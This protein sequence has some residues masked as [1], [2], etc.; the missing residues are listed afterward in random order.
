MLRNIKT[1]STNRLNAAVRNLQVFHLQKIP[2]RPVSS[3]TEMIPRSLD[4]SDLTDCVAG[5]AGLINI[6]AHSYVSLVI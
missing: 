1:D 4:T 3:L 2:G 5:R 6:F